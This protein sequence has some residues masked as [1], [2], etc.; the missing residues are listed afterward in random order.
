M[1]CL[2]GIS[3]LWRPDLHQ[4]HQQQRQMK[5]KAWE[6]S[7]IQ[8]LGQGQMSNS[9]SEEAQVQCFSD[10]KERHVQQASEEGQAR[11][12]RSAYGT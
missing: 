9:D 6:S 3:R 1:G 4:L 5:Q 8:P 10:P 7:L 12:W 2:T 11:H